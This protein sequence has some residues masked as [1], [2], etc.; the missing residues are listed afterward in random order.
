MPSG[1]AGAVEFAAPDPGPVGDAERRRV[2]LPGHLRAP[3]RIQVASPWSSTGTGSS[4]SLRSADHRMRGKAVDRPGDQARAPQQRLA[5][6]D[7]DEPVGLR[8]PDLAEVK[9][10]SRA[11][12]SKQRR[13]RRGRGRPATVIA[14]VHQPHVAAEHRREARRELAVEGPQLAQDAARAGSQASSR[15]GAR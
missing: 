8:R 14:Q 13:R 7:Q 3:A 4:V 2:G 15:A 9:A 5:A 10:E 1:L 12:G 6:G 11:P